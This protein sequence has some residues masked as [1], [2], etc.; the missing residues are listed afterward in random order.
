MKK[1]RRR[2]LD[3][4]EGFVGWHVIIA[5]AE[6]AMKTP[7]YKHSILPNIE[8]RREYLRRRDRALISALFLTG[9]RVSE[10]LMLRVENFHV[11]EEFIWV[12][13]MP[14]LK[15]YELKKE[16]VDERATPPPKEEAKNWRWNPEKGVFEKWVIEGSIPKVVE[17]PPFPIP[18]W[19]PLTDILLEWIEQ[20]EEKWLF[21]TPLSTRRAE[22]P[23]VQVWLETRFSLK[24]RPWI[25]PQ[26]TYQIVNNL[27]RRIGLII[28]DRSKG[29]KL[30]GIWDH[31]FR[32]QRAS[33]LFRDYQ[34]L[35]PHL[36]RFFGWA[37]G[38]TGKRK[39][40]AQ[41]YTGVGMA[42]LEDQMLENRSRHERLLKR[43]LRRKISIR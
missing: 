22:S 23:G 12:E 34:F 24:T 19:E 4:I 36:N 10:V 38:W 1:P 27:G 16:L 25:S 18:R 14:L 11:E 3:E 35:E 2:T 17:R 42:E 28:G 21:P 33:Q 8:S 32:S 7:Y 15:R 29:Q 20:S 43:D 5:L 39:T 9:G 13:G 41:R 37:G 31:W 6:E 26:R 40:M 30:E